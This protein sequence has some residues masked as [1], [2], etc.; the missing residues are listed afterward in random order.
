M[1][2]TPFPIYLCAPLY[3]IDLEDC[4]FTLSYDTAKEWILQSRTTRQFIEYRLDHT[5][6]G[7]NRAI[8][9]SYQGD[10]LVAQDS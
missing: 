9:H 4:F 6:T 1:R 7:F 10:I 5:L 2:V 8:I 3:G